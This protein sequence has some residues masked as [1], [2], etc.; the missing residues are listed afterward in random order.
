M[1]SRRH[2]LKGSCAF[3]LAALAGESSAHIPVERGGQ[4]I[5]K[6]KTWLPL[7]H[8]GAPASAFAPTERSTRIYLPAVQHALSDDL[9]LLG[10]ASATMAQAID[11]LVPRAVGYT[12]DD[13]ATIVDGYARIGA[14]V[15]LDWFLAL[16]QMAH[17]TG[18]LTSWWSQR[19]RRNPAGIGVTGATQQGIPDDP[20]GP[21]WAW[22]GA[23]W[24]EGVSFAGWLEHA[25]PAHLGRLLAY[26]LS[27]AQATPSQKNLIAYALTYRPLAS[28]YRGIA[29]TITGLNGRW[30]IPGTSYG[31]SIV[32][33]LGRMRDGV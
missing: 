22:D 32:D 24:R 1:P 7:I 5:F 9:P 17:E 11:W 29:P 8:L 12:A 19:P 3:L 31:Q 23:K 10:P 27:D 15:N 2:F 16:A 21:N 4:P 14:S 6:R 30:A 20:P 25:I 26:A 18:S 13:I 28:D 33:L